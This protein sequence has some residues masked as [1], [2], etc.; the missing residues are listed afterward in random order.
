MSLKKHLKRVVFACCALTL[1]PFFAVSKGINYPH[2]GPST[3]YLLS[4]N[5]DGEDSDWNYY[6]LDGGASYAVSLKT[7]AWTT[8]VNGQETTRSSITVPDHHPV[9]TEKKV[10]GIW[11]GGFYKC[12]IQTVNLTNNITVIDYEAFLGSAIT[13]IRIP[14]SVKE[15]GDAA[16]Y[17]CHELLSAHIAN[18]NAGASGSALTCS[19]APS[20]S[21]AS[22]FSSLYTIPSFCFFDCVKLKEVSF[23]TSLKHIE[24]EAFNGCAALQSKLYFEN[25]ETIRARAFQGCTSL[26]VVYISSSLF[27][28]PNNDGIEPHAFNYCNTDP[29]TG[30][31]ITFCAARG[32]INSWLAVGNHKYWGWH[33]D[34]GNPKSFIEVDDTNV[35]ILNSANC[36]DYEVNENTSVHYT[37]DWTYTI[38]SNDPKT[39]TITHYNGGIPAEE[40]YFVIP[41]EIGTYT[42]TRVNSDVFDE[43]VKPYVTRLYLPRTLVAIENNM[44]NSSYD[45]LVVIDTNDHC[46][47]D[48]LGDVTK[49][50]CLQSMTNLKYIGYRAF[51]EMDH[52]ADIQK[53]HLPAKIVAIGDE[54]FCEYSSS[55]RLKKVEE[56]YWN[57]IEG[58]SRLE[59]IGD[60]AFYKMG[61]DDSDME[62][63]NVKYSGSQQCTTKLVFPKTFKYFGL[64]D[65]DCSRYS[66][67]G[68]TF[69]R[70][71][72]DA[73][74]KYG[75]SAFA[76]CPLLR[77]VVFKGGANSEDLYI[78]MRTFFMNPSLQKIIFEE[79]YGENTSSPKWITFHTRNGNSL[80]PSIGG[81]SG[82]EKNDFRGD[83]ALQTIVL[84]NLYTKLRFQSYALQANSRAVLYFTGT[85]GTNIYQDTSLNWDLLLEDD[86]TTSP[87]T[88]GIKAWNKIGDEAF[89]T[90]SNDKGYIGYCFSSN[91]KT[92]VGSGYKNSFGL[93]QNMP[94]YYGVHYTG[95]INTAGITN[96]SV[97]SGVAHD[98]G[99][100]DYIEKSKC[101]F[102]ATATNTATMTKYLYDQRS[103]DNTS[104]TV[105]DYKIT[106]K[107]PS[108]IGPNDRYT[109]NAIGASAFSAAF[110]D[111]TDGTPKT[112]NKYNDISVVL[113]PDT[114]KTIG[115]YAF[116]RAYGVVELTAYCTTAS[117]DYHVGDKYPQY[118]MPSQLSASNKSTTVIGRNAFS[119][120]NIGQFL[121]FPKNC[122]FYECVNEGSNKVT[123]AFSNNFSLRRITFRGDNNAENNA[124]STYFLTT[125]YT[126]NIDGN[127]VKYTSALYSTAAT[128]KQGNRLLLVLN[129]D[130]GDYNQVSEDCN[131][132]GLFNGKYKSNPFL[133][134]AY[135][136]GY[137][138]KKLVLG[139]PTKNGNTILDQ[140]YFS[141]ICKRTITGNPATEALSDDYIYLFNAKNTYANLPCDL[142]VLLGDVLGS[143]AYAFDGCEQLKDVFLGRGSGGINAGIFKDVSNTE[144]KYHTIDFNNPNDIIGSEEDGVLDLSAEGYNYTSIG[145]NTFKNN[146]SIKAFIA[147]ETNEKFTIGASAFEG[148]EN[149]ETIDLSGLKGETTLET[150][151]FKKTGVKTLKWPND[152]P[153]YNGPGYDG[154]NSTPKFAKDPRNKWWLMISNVANGIT[155]K[156]SA[157]EDCDYLESVI[158]PQRL[159]YLGSTFDKDVRT[160]AFA[161]CDKLAS[162]D[163][164]DTN[165]LLMRIGSGAFSN[166]SKLDYF[167]IEKLKYIY[168][169][170]QRA[171]ENTGTISPNGE[172]VL[173]KTVSTIRQNAFEGSGVTNV[174]S[175][176]KFSR[177]DDVP[178]EKDTNMEERNLSIK[179]NCFQNTT[180]L[181]AAIF[182]S[183][184]NW[185]QTKAEKV[186]S[187]CTSLKQLVLPNRFDT[188]TGKSS[189][190]SGCTGIVTKNGSNVQ[191]SGLYLYT[192]YADRETVNNF[193][194]IGTNNAVPPCY[195]V[196]EMSDIVTS[197]SVP[198]DAYFWTANHDS[199]GYLVGSPIYLG[200][201]T[202]NG[203]QVTFESGHIL[204]SSGF[205]FGITGRNDYYKDGELLDNNVVY[206]KGDVILGTSVSYDAITDTVLFSNGFRLD[207]SGNIIIQVTASTSSGLT[208]N[209]ALVDGAGDK[210]YWFND[211]GSVVLL[212]NA[213]AISDGIV[214]F[215]SSFKLDG[216]GNLSIIINGYGNP[217]D[218]KLVKGGQ[219]ISTSATY[220]YD[221]GSASVVLGTATGFYD[222]VGVT[223]SNGYLLGTDSTL[224]ALITADTALDSLNGNYWCFDGDGITPVLLGESSSYDQTSRTALFAVDN[225]R[226]IIEE[227]DVHLLYS[228]ETLVVDGTEIAANPT[229]Y[230]WYDNAGSIL[231]LGQP[232]DYDPNSQTNGF[233]EYRVDAEHLYRQITD[234]NDISSLSNTTYYWCYD[235]GSVMLLG[236]RDSYTDGV[237]TFSE[238]YVLNDDWEFTR[239]ITTYSELLQ[240]GSLISTSTVYTVG[241]NE[242]GTALNYYEGIGI[243]F[244]SG[245]MLDI[246]NNL[247]VLLEDEA[248][249]E[250]LNAETSYWVYDAAA[251]PMVL[252]Q[253]SDGVFD[254]NSGTIKFTIGGKDYRVDS[255]GHLL[256]QIVTIEDWLAVQAFDIAARANTYYY[257]VDPDGNV[258]A[259]GY[260][261]AFSAANAEVTFSG[262][263]EY[264]YTIGP[265]PELGKTPKS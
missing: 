35:E 192:K 166:C 243:V 117:G 108:K 73:P 94:E 134:G 229:K 260:A 125:T 97:E 241:G 81:S 237:V 212:G 34:R 261:T 2:V 17:G 25:I 44:F 232:G 228:A 70:K 153:S 256:Y 66:E 116:L 123:S 53:I 98:N 171:F 219:L 85:K 217:Q 220:T 80:T 209:G 174:L 111:G 231:V 36:F 118:T 8:I 106:L 214:T 40:H 233:G 89:Y 244:S 11:H 107:V 158:L 230:Y 141:G 146:K 169:I 252:G 113:I 263:G 95:T 15:I 46:E 145:A 175:L 26:K 183:Q 110:C 77:E 24:Y 234:T 204:T 12:P 76:G 71:T 132:T 42:V 90:E 82:R 157:F 59:T 258:I 96:V 121:N 131:A 203:S 239:T 16:F 210:Y 105:S 148:C 38:T 138:I 72:M 240:N 130:Y 257:Y 215:S 84:P 137:W 176:K 225:L 74:N 199:D 136:M 142:M 236:T 223:F 161:Y 185:D 109:V 162:V 235:N 100:G 186:F 104:E 67:D 167:A 120:C 83:P 114:I 172:L 49:R 135:K 23:P 32:V 247:H 180:Q 211:N 30:L 168:E 4:G 19:C 200:K 195:F 64:L 33:N 65:D 57:Y 139:T 177:D 187:G 198:N 147:P 205:S 62:C 249:L 78:P 213:N 165:E 245:Y 222:D 5:K 189:F 156:D 259:L 149:L 69:E 115:D 182:Q 188:K 155:V 150:A 45:K 218:S 206:S 242:L 68:F 250:H 28:N 91:V 20:E 1:F 7:S 88:N 93:D 119:F 133:F 248:D 3:K 112:N 159:M 101:A 79:R 227:G 27:A 140:A 99:I 151:C 202:G 254:S 50:I 126:K 224:Y 216:S 173:N 60:S 39:A 87:G 29:T 178:F 9:H 102:V 128:N 154:T 6:L 41:D 221:N 160:G 201:A 18:S 61:C 51:P 262:D 48:L 86:S 226:V 127:D 251:K 143:Q 52:I 124:S 193:N 13:S 129:R 122:T 196:S 31:K 58:E 238:G 191:Y 54:A 43:D 56:F 14:Y 181:V 22:I 55:K 144:I 21:T 246:E 264:I 47:N 152:P 184:A 10:T 194:I 179:S 208:S 163:F 265:S 75:S 164:Y 255:S 37:D 63:K 92:D 253:G 197:G 103:L 170:N 190:L 207:A